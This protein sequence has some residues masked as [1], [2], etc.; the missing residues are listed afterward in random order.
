MEGPAYILT[1]VDKE[2]EKYSIEI[3]KIANQY[4]PEPKSMVIKVV[5][6]RLLG[7]TGGIVQGMSGSPII[8][9]DRLIGI[10]TH[11]FVNDPSRGYA[12]FA[13][14]MVQNAKAENGDNATKVDKTE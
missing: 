11:V 1:T 7:A 9:G 12:I 6:E 13:E 2:I 8:Q 14:W 4:H 5:D 3:Q 10:V